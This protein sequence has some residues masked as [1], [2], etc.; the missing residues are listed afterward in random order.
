M[1]RRLRRWYES[2]VIER[3]FHDL[4]TDHDNEYIM[5]DSTIGRTHQHSPGALK[6]GALIRRSRSDL[7]T[8]I[9]AICDALDTPVKPALTQ[10][11]DTDI[12]QV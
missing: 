2:N 11:Q 7:T 3:I 1:Y 8:K 10:G 6:K 9:H 5:S 12:A 4:A